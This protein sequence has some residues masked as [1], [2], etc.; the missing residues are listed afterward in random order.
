M[1]KWIAD[2]LEW[3]KVLLA[4]APIAAMIFACVALGLGWMT[5]G[6]WIA[7]MGTLVGAGGAGVYAVSRSEARVAEAKAAEAKARAGAPLGD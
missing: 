7:S 3:K 2:V 6:E 4:L 5:A 1:K